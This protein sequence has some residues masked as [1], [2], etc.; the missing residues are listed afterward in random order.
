MDRRLPVKHVGAMPPAV[1]RQAAPVVAR[2][3]AFVLAGI[4][5]EWLLR[6]AVQRTIGGIP[7]QRRAR[8]TSAD[9]TGGEVAI[10]E[11]VIMRRVTVRR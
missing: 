10:S 3:A 8:R 11:T 2:G 4:A 7:A 9:R 1:W 5:A 6:R